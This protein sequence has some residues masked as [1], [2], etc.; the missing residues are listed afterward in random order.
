MRAGFCE[1]D[2][3]NY[4][5]DHPS[6]FLPFLEKRE[7]VSKKIEG[8]SVKIFWWNILF[9]PPKTLDWD[10]LEQNLSL[11]SRDSILSPDVM[12]LGE[13]RRSVRKKLVRDLSE[14]YPYQH[15]IP[16]LGRFDKNESYEILVFSKNPILVH[17]E[18]LPI[19]WNRRSDQNDDGWQVDWKG[20]M[21]RPYQKLSIQDEDRGEYFLL[22]FHANQ[23]WESI[24]ERHE[25]TG[26]L[27][28]FF[29]LVSGGKDPNTIQIEN[30]M[31][32]IENDFRKRPGFSDLP[33]V[34]LGDFNFPTQ[35]G[36]PGSKVGIK[37]ASYR[38]IQE[39]LQDAFMG[40]NP[41]SFPSIS[42][43][44]S[45]YAF[46]IDHAFTSQSVQV[47][48]ADVFPFMGSDHYPI[49]VVFNLK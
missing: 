32:Q 11:L 40:R 14:V 48:S 1:R 26:K 2:S 45:Q 29:D 3:S 7:M 27:R 6:G 17:G 43:G 39:V 19:A 25:K 18:V 49:Y 38:R 16:Y 4:C 21:T 42:S 36:I 15:S 8:S 12:V 47:H 37:T 31:N 41:I 13:V 22:P 44:V 46:K 24:L 20:L 10:V 34:L 33:V 23:P 9:N 28:V 30:L 35:V 5:V